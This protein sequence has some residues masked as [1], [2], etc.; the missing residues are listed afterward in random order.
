MLA[1]NAASSPNSSIVP[2]LFIGI[3]F[4]IPSTTDSGFDASVSFAIPST[5][6]VIIYPGIIAL[7]LI[8]SSTSSAAKAFVNPTNAAFVVA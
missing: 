4:A 3:P 7:T 1:R 8:L 5:I 2:S 6:G